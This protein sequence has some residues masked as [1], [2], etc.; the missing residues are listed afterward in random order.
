MSEPKFFTKGET[1]SWTRSFN[2]YPATEWDLTYYF[3]GRT[4]GF[5]IAA[6]ADGTSFIAETPSDLT[7]GAGVYQWQAQVTN[8]EKTIVVDSGNV[9][10]LPNF[11]GIQTTEGFDGRTQTEKDLAAVKEMLS[12]K[13]SKDV[14]SYQIGN[15]QLQHISINDLLALKHELTKDVIKERRAKTRKKGSPFFKTVNVRLSDD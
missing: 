14:Q 12:G 10:I 13:A 1:I 9:E 5:D 2:D 6:A 8:G 7:N 11:A 4:N 3:R 15:R